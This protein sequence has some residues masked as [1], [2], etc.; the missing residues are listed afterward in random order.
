MLLSLITELIGTFVFLSVI[1]KTGE[2]PSQLVLR[3]QL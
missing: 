3:L 2:V 1:V